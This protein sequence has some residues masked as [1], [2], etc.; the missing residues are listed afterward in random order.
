MRA[1]YLRVASFALF[2]LFPGLSFADDLT[3][4]NDVDLIEH[5]REAVGAQD[6]A[7]TLSLMSEMQRRKT[8]IFAAGETTVCRE[9]IELPGVITD[10]R[11]RGAARQ[12]YITAAKEVQLAASS[13]RCLFAGYSFDAFTRALL[14]KSPNDLTD[15]DR[16]ALEAYVGRSQSKVDA[17]YRALETTCRVK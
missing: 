5:T 2:F 11:F 15:A 3:T 9:V 14:G 4:L 7:A 13:C 10:W 8:G 16:S 6:A 17:R 1:H 12:A